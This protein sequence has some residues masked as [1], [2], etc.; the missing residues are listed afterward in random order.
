MDD[1]ILDPTSTPLE[2][3]L[4]EIKDKDNF[5][6][7]FEAILEYLKVDALSKSTVEHNY[8]AYYKCN[9]RDRSFHPT[10]S[11]NAE[12]NAQIFYAHPR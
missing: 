5:D 3:M 10:F 11:D 12:L 8:N 2:L 1:N 4:E 9:M 7:L 6:E